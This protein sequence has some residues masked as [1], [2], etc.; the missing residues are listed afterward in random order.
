MFYQDA[1]THTANAGSSHRKYFMLTIEIKGGKDI[2]IFY[3]FT[4]NGDG[5]NDNFR[6]YGIGLQSVEMVIYNRW[7][8]RCS[9]TCQPGGNGKLKVW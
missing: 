1:G 2:Y 6:I 4:L 7:A 9:G 8:V 5:I 3:V